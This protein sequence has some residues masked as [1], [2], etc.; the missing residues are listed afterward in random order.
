MAREADLVP[1]LHRRG[2]VFG[3]CDHA[4]DALAA[5]RFGVRPARSVAILAGQP[6]EHVAGL[7]EEEPAHLRVREP[8]PGVLVTA[9]AGLRAG[10]SG[11]QFGGGRRRWRRGDWLLGRDPR[12]E[13]Q[14]TKYQ[15]GDRDRTEEAEH[16]ESPSAHHMPALAPAR[17]CRTATERL[18]HGGRWPAL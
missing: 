18:L 3:E 14:Q 12:G 16:R 1:L 15:E 17:H 10:V 8:V 2:V 4:A 7:L 13:R 9:L 6:L 5:A 11:R